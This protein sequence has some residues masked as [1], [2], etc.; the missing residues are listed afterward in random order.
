MK[1]ASCQVSFAHSIALSLLLQ[2]VLF[3]TINA[4]CFGRGEECQVVLVKCFFLG[5]ATRA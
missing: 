5:I 1:A 4:N 2:V 3:I